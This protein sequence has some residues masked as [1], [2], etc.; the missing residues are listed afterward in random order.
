MTLEVESSDT[1]NNCLPVTNSRMVVLLELTLRS[2]SRRR[3]SLPIPSITSRRRFRKS[4]PFSVDS[5]PCW[6]SSLPIRFSFRRAKSL[7]FWFLS[8]TRRL[9]QHH[10]QQDNHTDDRNL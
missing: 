1:I 4:T 8:T 10:Q 3:P 5:P 6:R 2:P 7:P 9:F